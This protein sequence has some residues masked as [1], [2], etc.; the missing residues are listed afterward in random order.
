MYLTDIEERFLTHFSTPAPKGF[1]LK[2]EYLAMCHHM[3]IHSIITAIVSAMNQNYND[4][5]ATKIK[6]LFAAVS[7]E[8]VT[9]DDY[10][11]GKTYVEKLFDDLINN[12]ISHSKRI[13]IAQTLLTRLNQTSKN[14][15]P[16][17]AR[18]NSS[19][20][21]HID[22]HL[23]KHKDSGQY[24]ETERSKAIREV[25]LAFFLEAN[26]PAPEVRQNE[27][28]MIQSSSFMPEN[29]DLVNSYVSVPSFTP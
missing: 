17:S 8:M 14:L 7:H 29:N 18:A 25:C 13:E 5:Q 20:G 10:D 12:N 22:L 2:I 4:A 16:G 9:T 6:Q 24:V 27:Q 19:I 11:T 21:G 3:S 23:N 28:G 26:S 15:M 1:S